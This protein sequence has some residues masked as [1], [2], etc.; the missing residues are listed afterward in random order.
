MYRYSNKAVAESTAN[1][2]LFTLFYG[3]EKEHHVKI[4]SVGTEIE[5]TVIADFQNGISVALLYSSEVKLVKPC[6]L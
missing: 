4:T 5:I 2:Q 1:T 3:L 6:A